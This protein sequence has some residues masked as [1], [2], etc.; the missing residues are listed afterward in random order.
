MYV[1]YKKITYQIRLFY[2]N[3]ILDL[4]LKNHNFTVKNRYDF[5]DGFL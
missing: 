1:V 5:S 3:T 4:K 2:R